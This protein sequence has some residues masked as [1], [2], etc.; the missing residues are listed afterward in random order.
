[1]SEKNEIAVEV[2]GLSKSYGTVEALKSIDLKIDMGEYFVLLGP[3]GGGKTT[4]LRLIGGFI[5]PTEGQVFLHNQEVSHLPPNARPTSMVFQSFA[6]FPH[7]TVAQ[8]VGYGL[9]LKRVKA[10]EIHDK[11]TNMLETVGLDGYGDRM[12]HELSGGQQQRVQLARSFVLETSILLLDE[13]LAALDA[14]L[15]RD[16]CIELKRLQEKIGMTF[17]HVTHNQEEAMTVADNM[18][19]I[20]DGNLIEMGEPSDLYENPIRRFTADFIGANNIFDGQVIKVDDGITYV[21]L[22]SSSISVLS[23][24]QK[25]SVGD[26]VSVSVRSELVCA[27]NASTVNVEPLETLSGV[28]RESV[29]L[30]LTTS[31]LVALENGQEVLARRISNG[32]DAH[33]GANGAPINV[34]WRQQ[35]GRLHIS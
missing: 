32:S 23:R 31:E 27:I 34:G 14:N 9:R 2:K 17:I 18:A 26:H 19:I 10:S 24:G 35:D 6:L 28:H 7:M 12:P 22:G 4:L 16:M 5:R 30:G 20:A 11:V 1:M 3:S 15:R 25:T 33:I 29:Y 13:P 8:N 21:D